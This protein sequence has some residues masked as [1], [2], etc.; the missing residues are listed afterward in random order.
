MARSALCCTVVLL[1]ALTWLYAA[2]TTVKSGTIESVSEANQTVTVKFAHAETATELK[3]AKDTSI[4]LDGASAELTAL[5]PGMSVTV[6]VGSENEAERILA[7][8]AKDNPHP[9]TAA[10]SPKPKTTARKTSKTK[11]SKTASNSKKK[12][13]T[14]ASAL[15]SLP[16]MTTPLAGLKNTDA[17]GSTA[18]NSPTGSGSKGGSARG[19]WPCFL[20]PNHD[21]ISKETGLLTQWPQQGPAPAWHLPGL[22]AGYSAVS[23]SGKTLFSMGT[24]DNQEALLAIS[25]E[26]KALWSVPTGGPVFQ[27]SHGGGP[28][29]TPTVDGGRVYALGASGDLI[30]VDI[31]SKS[32]VW[33]KNLT[34]EFSATVPQYGYSESVLI[35]GSKLICTPGGQGATLAA[36]NKDTGAVLWKCAVPTA[37]AAYGSP[38]V[39]EVGG[40]RQ[41]INVVNRGV[42]GVKTDGQLLWGN[43]TIGNANVICSSPLFIK[44]HVFVSANYGAGAAL[45]KLAPGDQSGGGGGFQASVI[46]HSLDMN[47]HHGGMVALGNFVYGA[48]DQVLTCL[49]LVSGKAVWRNRSVGKCS[50][51]YADGHLYVRGEQDGAVALVEASPNGYHE[52][53]RFAPPKN[54]TLPAWS[55]PVVAAGRLFL[56]DQDDLLCYSLK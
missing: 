28:R 32:V 40:I 45:I 37:G 2:G 13:D 34:Q 25:L 33:H 51:T 27:E 42:V 5:K 49:S 30:C 17:K 4:R 12:S 47:N 20:G 26:G 52:A 50:L 41:Y 9:S 1:S 7:H 56:R 22:G 19:D 48:N 29:G 6:Q 10:K 31:N 24:P 55:Y 15:D 54:N 53:G 46:F 8:T 35:D 14:S 11:T 3:L 16:V 38:I 21:N 23:L 36:L 43:D 39:A 18:V 44:D